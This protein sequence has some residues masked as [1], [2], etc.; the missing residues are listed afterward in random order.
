MLS[1]FELLPAEIRQIIYNYLGFLPVSRIIQ[2]HY[3]NTE[4]CRCKGRQR[5]PEHYPESL[6]KCTSCKTGPVQL[7][8]ICFTEPFM[9]RV[10]CIATSI[11][12]QTIVRPQGEFGRAHMS[13]C[14][15]CTKKQPWVSFATG[16]M[17]VNKR[18][19]AELCQLLYSGLTVHFS[20]ELSGQPVHH[21]KGEWLP[22]RYNRTRVGYK[23][24]KGYDQSHS[25]KGY[26][27]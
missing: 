22:F 13:K 20:F 11:S 3:W 19:H 16:L 1:R 2:V 23:K 25:Y 10:F 5:I 7:S 12:D 21:D 18:L 27:Q 6:R 15:D 4:Q 14:T 17:C 9:K 26:V 24:Y 8:D